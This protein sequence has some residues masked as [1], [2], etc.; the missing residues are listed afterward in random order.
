MFISGSTETR[1]ASTVVEAS[2]HFPS[3]FCGPNDRQCPRPRIVHC[4]RR[5]AEQRAPL[6]LDHLAR[7]KGHRLRRHIHTDLYVPLGSPPRPIS[8]IANLPR[9]SFSDSTP[10]PPNVK[11]AVA[12]SDITARKGNIGARVG[13]RQPSSV[14]AALSMH[15]ST[16]GWSTSYQ[17]S[18]SR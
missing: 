4:F 3:I 7:S 15:T 14:G 6:R 16:H 10:S 18:S 12:R 5:Q 9:S 8:V 13:R 1:R 17:A 11:L 2:E